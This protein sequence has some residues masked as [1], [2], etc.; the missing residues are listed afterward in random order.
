MAIDIKQEPK[1]NA[2]IG[3]QARDVGGA[4]FAVGLFGDQCI[5][6]SHDETQQHHRIGNQGDAT[7]INRSAKEA[8]TW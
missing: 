4:N 8:L 7:R 1:L 2:N 6:K 5:L 3:N